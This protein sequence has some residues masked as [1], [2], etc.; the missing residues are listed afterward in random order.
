MRLAQQVLGF[1]LDLRDSVSCTR[2][3]TLVQALLNYLSNAVKFTEKGYISLRGRLVEENE[4][5]V[6]L[7][8]EV[9]DTGIGMSAAQRMHLFEV[10]QQADDSMT[11]VLAVQAWVCRSPAVLPN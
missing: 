3:E 10:F 4:R 11:V 1:Q 2:D 6:L 5:E 9:E 8:F 7:R